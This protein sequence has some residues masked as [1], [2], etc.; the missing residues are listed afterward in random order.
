MKYQTTNQGYL[1]T[2]NKIRDA[3]FSLLTSKNS[4]KKVTV[5]EVCEVA[6]IRRSTFYLH[7]DGIEDIINQISA[8][9]FVVIKKMIPPVIESAQDMKD[10]IHNYVEYF[11]A[12]S[13][14]ITP[15]LKDPEFEHVFSD[16]QEKTR[17]ALK[18]SML[19]GNKNY[20]P[21]KA[22]LILMGVLTL[23]ERAAIGK[24]DQS[25]DLIEEAAK[26]L[27]DTVYE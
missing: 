6:G 20:S 15:I 19:K 7:Y 21:G 5:S 12:K 13:K 1:K 27:Y 9:S 22:A 2:E 11:K 14:Y 25:F 3:F 23:L 16:A 10:F 26:D 17:L 24:T 18:E 8:N 4:I